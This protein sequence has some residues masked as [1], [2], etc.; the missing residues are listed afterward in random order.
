[1]KRLT[2]MR[3]AKSDWNNPNLS[4]FDRPLNRRGFC[5]A[6]EMGRRYAARIGSPDCIHTSTAVR[7]RQTA[8]LFAEQAAYDAD[9]IVAHDELY[10]A[11]PATLLDIVNQLED[12]DGHVVV[13]AHNPGITE[14]ATELTGGRLDNLPTAGI[15][16]M[17]FDQPGWENIS[18]GTGVLDWFDFPKNVSSA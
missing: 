14:F 7:A 13:I 8:G 16:S 18:P 2:L 1:M 5:D 9:E 12:R 3:H 6:P 11:S 4:D 15:W 10:L 17:L